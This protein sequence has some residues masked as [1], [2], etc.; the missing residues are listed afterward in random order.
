M[1]EN[2]DARSNYRVND[3]FTSGETLDQSDL[4]STI[5]GTIITSIITVSLIALNA[6]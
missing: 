1:I 5:R 4:V 2:D 3:N 6:N